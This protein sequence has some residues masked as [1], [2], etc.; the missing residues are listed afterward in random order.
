MFVRK[1]VLKKN[2]EILMRQNS[3]LNQFNTKLQRENKEIK[4]ENEVLRNKNRELENSLLITSDEL[5]EKK[6][7][8]KKLKQTL[9]RNKISYKKEN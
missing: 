5:D 7:E 9:T 6:K 4:D 1:K 3:E 2:N 8:C